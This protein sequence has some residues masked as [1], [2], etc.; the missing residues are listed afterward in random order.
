MN[1]VSFL[2]LLTVCLQKLCLKLWFI[3]PKA[4]KP[5]ILDLLNDWSIQLVLVNTE[6][7]ACST[8]GVSPVFGM[9]ELA[10]QLSKDKSLY[11]FYTSHLSRAYN[12]RFWTLCHRLCYLICCSFIWRVLLA[13][14]LVVVA[15]KSF[16]E[17]RVLT[18]LMKRVYRSKFKVFLLVQCVLFVCILYYQTK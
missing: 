3:S 15:L 11:S 8:S 4:S 2:L 13:P 1:Y 12:R 5:N 7:C 14:R 6:W 16:N 17:V 9:P 10:L 18:A